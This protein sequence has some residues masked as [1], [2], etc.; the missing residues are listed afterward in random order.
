MRKGN[1]KNKMKISPTKVKLTLN[2]PSSAKR[3]QKK[4]KVHYKYYPQILLL[5]PP[6]VF[7]TFLILQV[8]SRTQKS[9]YKFF[10]FFLPFVLR[11]KLANKLESPC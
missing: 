9:N 2:L 6:F 5:M 4:L 7:L 1:K 3:K 8:Y 11:P 10:F